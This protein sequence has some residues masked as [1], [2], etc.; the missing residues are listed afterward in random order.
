VERVLGGAACDAPVSAKLQA[1]LEIASLVRGGGREVT[2]EAVA[3]ARDAG[4][5]DREIH[6]TVLIAATFCMLNRY[7]DGLATPVPDDPGQYAVSAAHLVRHG[8]RVPR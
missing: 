2:D 5:T 3:G 4:A 6:D 8:Y 7:V 1:L